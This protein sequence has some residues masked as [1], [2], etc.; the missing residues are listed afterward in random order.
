[1]ARA[2]GA[3]RVPRLRTLLRI[4]SV[5]AAAAFPP[6]CGPDSPA[7]GARSPARG[8]VSPPR[9][10]RATPPRRGAA[11]RA[12]RAPPPPPR[13]GRRQTGRRGTRKRAR[14]AS[15]AARW[16]S[17]WTVHRPPK[18]LLVY[19]SVGLKPLSIAPTPMVIGM[20]LLSFITAR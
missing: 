19:S 7:A 20:S 14:R 3:S 4:P 13:G 16:P 6:G 9:R 18:L 11:P 8:G 10:R 12:A 1:G 15:P 2:L 17:L 5:A